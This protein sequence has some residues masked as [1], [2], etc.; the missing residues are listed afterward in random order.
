MN[1]ERVKDIADAVLF[2]GYILYP[3]RPSAIK[4]QQRWTF[5]GLFPRDYQGD[6]PSLMQTEIL[7]RAGRAAE[8]DV[9]ARFLHMQ[10]RQVAKARE[11]AESDKYE[12]VAAL[13][14]D[15][16]QSVT[17]DEAIVRETRLSAVSVSEL[18]YRPLR[19]AISLPARQT[20]EAIRSDTGSIAG[21]IVRRCEA[22]EGAVEVAAERVAEELYRLRVRLENIT[23]LGEFL[24]RADAQRYAFLSTHTILSARDAEFVSLLE[25][26]EPFAAA[27]AACDNRGTWPVLAGEEGARDMALSSPIILYDYPKV[28]PE[29]KSQFFDA[30]EIDELLALR[31]LTLTDEEKREMA[32][33]DPRAKAILDRCE[34]LTREELFDLHGAFRNPPTPLGSGALAVGSHVRLHPKGRSDIFDIALKDRIG[35]VRSLER[36]FENRVHVAVTLLD[37]PGGDLGEEGFPGHRFFFSAEEVEPVSVGVVT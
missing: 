29:S 14:V 13:E 35:V 6:E 17:W 18:L 19:V 31:V 1:I 21:R 9:V 20:A 8:V 16:K 3:Y 2:E 26:P 12:P 22:L 4:N 15:G 34:A 5:G 30:T 33:T 32:A 11:A 27:A 37:D 24:S 25:P 7:L 10:R 28:A 36:D 23:P